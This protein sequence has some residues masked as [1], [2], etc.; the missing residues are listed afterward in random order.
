MEFISLIAPQEL[1][2]ERMVENLYYRRAW[3]ALQDSIYNALDD[4]VLQVTPKE[5]LERMDTCLA[6]VTGNISLGFTP[7]KVESKNAK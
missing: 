3:L 4:M 2:P 1:T 6:M 5:I 7:N